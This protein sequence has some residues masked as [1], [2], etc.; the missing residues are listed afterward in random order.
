MDPAGILCVDYGFHATVTLELAREVHRLHRR[1]AGGR[2]VPVLI[3]GRGI[4]DVE[5]EAYRFAQRPEVNEVT[6]AVALL[7]TTPLERYLA[8]MF[9]LYHRP[10]HPVRV[11]S[12]ERAA[13]DWLR[14]HVDP[15]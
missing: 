9:L 8:Q 3:K 7:A 10:A 15:A 5:W 13:M 2:R 6:A 11:F 4:L 1:L 14:Q 12:D